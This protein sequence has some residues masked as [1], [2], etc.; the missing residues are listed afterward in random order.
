MT[1]V[2][3]LILGTAV[4]II[5]DFAGWPSFQLAPGGVLIYRFQAGDNGSFYFYGQFGKGAFYLGLLGGRPQC[6][7]RG[8]AGLA[9]HPPGKARSELMP[10]WGTP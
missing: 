6:R 2:G 7:F 9:G 5:G 4:A 1:Y 8:L 3:L 10:P